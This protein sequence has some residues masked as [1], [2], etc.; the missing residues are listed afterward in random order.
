MKIK[1]YDEVLRLLYCLWGDRTTDDYQACWEW[2]GPTTGGGYGTL[3]VDGEHDY[4]HRVAWEVAHGR[5]L[6]D[7]AVVRHACDNPVCVNPTHLR[8]G[9]QVDNMQDCVERSR[10][11]RGNRHPNS[12]LTFEQVEETRE[13]WER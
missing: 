9:S 6:P 1:T 5:R 13:I 3:S 2:D 10:F 12:K 8:V 4:S 11:R 7:G